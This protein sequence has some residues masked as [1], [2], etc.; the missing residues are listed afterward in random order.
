VAPL[1]FYKGLAVGFLMCAPIG[2]I[3]LVCVRRTIMD[4]RK[5]GMASVLGASTVDAIYCSVAGLSI[6]FLTG[7]LQGE[8]QLFQAAGGMV[9]MAVGIRIFMASVPVAKV[10]KVTDGVVQAFV[11]TFLLTL[12]NP[13]PI[14]VF[15]AAFTVLGI[16]GWKG[17]S[18][19][20][21]AMVAGVF[22][23]SALWSP[24][25]VTIVTLFRPQFNPSRM[26]W[27]SRLTGSLIALI[28]LIAEIGVF[29][30]W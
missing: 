16:H 21:A 20:T 9:L 15:S 5:A 25:L 29:I 11:S 26:R 4:G 10:Y 8:R 27:F 14:L 30:T 22:A 28:G 2:P 17:E 7:L 6:A 12:A 19:S 13:M 23:G 3:G 1:I 24:I 18:L